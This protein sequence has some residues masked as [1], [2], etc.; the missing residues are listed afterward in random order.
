MGADAV[1][2]MPE[3]VRNYGEPF[4]DSSAIPTYI[5]SRLARRHVKMVLTGDGGDEGF[6]GYSRYRRWHKQLNAQRAAWKRLLRPGLQ[7]L[8]P[9]RFPVRAPIRPHDWLRRIQSIGA[10]GRRQIWRPEFAHVVEEPIEAIEE[11]MKDALVVPREQIG[12]YIDY[13]TY[14]PHDILT[15]VDI[16]SMSNGL[17]SRTPLADVRVAEF[18]ATIPWEENL[19]RNANGELTGKR[20]LKAVVEKHFDNEFIERKKSGFAI[21]LLHWFARGGALRQPLKD[22]LSPGNANVYRYF[23]P[24]AVQC[25]IEEHGLDGRDN[26]QA[27]WQLLF[28]ET[29]L[30]S[31]RYAR[32][33]PAR[34]F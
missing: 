7:L 15:K 20:L 17:E 31:A 3:L 12:Q 27:L 5:V 13:R 18:A 28:L 23:R 8:M 26:S 2:N 14:L 29:W 32:N 9:K 1:S 19:A 10:E 33:V 11:V 6:L 30:D 25:L 4:G 16:A 22:R 24:E 34:P 21:P